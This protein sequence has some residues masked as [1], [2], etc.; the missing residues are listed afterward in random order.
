[1]KVK[2]KKINDKAT[3]PKKMTSGA[4]AFDLYCANSVV[5]EYKIPTLVRLGFCVEIESGY[6]MK[7]LPRS[8]M[9]LDGISI[10]N[11]PGL[12]DEDYRGEVCV[13]L[14]NNNPQNMILKEGTRVAQARLEKNEKVEF[15][16]VKELSVTDRM[17]GG[18][19][20]TGK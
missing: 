2:I 10:S 15:E 12:I 8:G 6:C 18:F 20:S 14:C 17:G 11:A 5:L 1:M 3:I 19:G 7:I 9:A 16:E 4:A 13:I